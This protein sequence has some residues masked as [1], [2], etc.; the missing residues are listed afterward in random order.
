MRKEI[1][2]IFL[3]TNIGAYT[4]ERN[5]SSEFILWTYLTQKIKFSDTY[6]GSIGTQYRSF[7]DRAGDY[8]LFF[9]AMITGKLGH[10]FSASLGFMNLNINQFVDT[11]HVLVPELRPVQSIQFSYPINK[12]AFS[13]RLMTEQRFFRKAANGE[14][15]NG[16]IHNWRFR[17]RFAYTQF[18]SEKFKL[19]WS[20]EVMINAGDIGVNIFDQHRTQAMLTYDIGKWNVESGYMHW[21]FQTSANH[22][23]NRHTWMIGL[24]HSL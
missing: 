8:H 15:V 3:F 10:G 6:S 17:N 14:L 1:I 20:S 18:L 19:I 11:E 12:S 23:E 21:F 2:I 7:T 5:L 13:W 9:F 16:Y 22:H 24:S 4:Q